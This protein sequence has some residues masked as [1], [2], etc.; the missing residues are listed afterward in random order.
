MK[1]LRTPFAFFLVIA[2][3]GMWCVLWGEVTIANVVSGAVLA[4][5]FVAMS[6]TGSGGHGV[7]PFAL[8]KFL[9]VVAVDLAKSTAAVAV[10]VLTL[11]DRTEETI[12]VV[13]PSPERLASPLLMV[14]A[15]TIT[16]GTGV[17]DVDTETGLLYLHLLHGQRAD[18]VTAHVRRLNGLANA[19][20]PHLDGA[21]NQR[22]WSS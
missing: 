22:A 7:R 5:V 14:V 21:S 2:L 18:E 8:V 10:E 17:V 1:G 4:A 6:S 12:I 16:P 13:D 20:L 11:T 3:T 19:A 15:I 9:A